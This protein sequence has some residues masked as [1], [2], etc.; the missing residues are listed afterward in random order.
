SLG[1]RLGETRPPHVYVEVVDPA[2]AAGGRGAGDAHD[3]CGRRGR[4]WEQ[5]EVVGGERDKQR[6]RRDHGDHAG[7]GERRDACRGA[8]AA[9]GGRVAPPPTAPMSQ[10]ADALASPR[11]TGPRTFARLPHVEDLAG[12]DVAVFGMPSDAGTSF[13]PGARFGPEAV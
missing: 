6:R 12:V 11:F 5:D 1:P 3:G 10:P 7:N 4:A 13:R 9:P 2:P 8:G